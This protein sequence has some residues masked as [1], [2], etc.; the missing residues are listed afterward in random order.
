[1]LLYRLNRTTLICSFAVL[2]L[3][4]LPSR[5]KAQDC[6]KPGKDFILMEDSHYGFIIS[7]RG[8]IV[9]LIKGHIGGGELSYIFRTC[10]KYS[11]QGIHAFPEF[12]VSAMHLYL[13]NPT[14]IGNLDAIYPFMNLRI[15]KQRRSFKMYIRIGCGLSWMSKPFDRLENHRNNAIGSNVNGFV[16]LRL[17]SSYMLSPSWRLDSGVGLTHSSNGAMKTPNLGLNMATVNLGLGYVFGNKC[18]EMK[19]D[20]I[21]PKVSKRW[22][23]LVIATFGV[24][25]LEHP[26]GNKF[27]SYT[28]N[29]NEYY[30]TNLKNKFGTGVEFCYS[31]A[32][33]KKLESESV[34]TERIK[35][36][37][38]VG[39]KFG[40][41][42]T[43]DRLSIPLDFGMYIFQNDNLKERFFHRIGFRYMVTKH[44]VANVTLYTHWAKADYFE[45]GLGYEF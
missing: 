16:N 32:T 6:P 25:E 24:K 33:R 14:E 17:S 10:G 39:V 26:L 30:S 28:L 5:S 29:A 41:A 43:I 31:N 27:L 19:C 40:Y 21:R 4:F 36:V 34:S 20:S 8:S 44:V 45:W 1:M 15:N 42:F 12:G 2:S 9:H 22:H 18:L 35:D 13:A 3:L 38:K 23:S 7:H 37:L 11:W